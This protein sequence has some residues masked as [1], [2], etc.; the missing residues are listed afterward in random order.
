[1]RI[2]S[3]VL[4]LIWLLA[5]LI[6]LGKNRTRSNQDICLVDDAGAAMNKCPSK[7]YQILLIL[8]GN[9][10][11][12]LLFLCRYPQSDTALE[13]TRQ[14]D[15]KSYVKF[16][17]WLKLSTFVKYSA[18]L[19]RSSWNHR[20]SP[21][22]WLVRVQSGWGCAGLATSYQLSHRETMPVTLEWSQ[23]S[24]KALDEFTKAGKGRWPLTKW[25][26]S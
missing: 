17:P 5:L 26:L 20:L 22:F 12:P 8:F 18:L 14:C 2:R 19:P 10:K 1:M 23:Y 6:Q 4:L 21:C 25:V 9:D 24:S 3:K 16:S 15:R 13:W 7:Y 11:E